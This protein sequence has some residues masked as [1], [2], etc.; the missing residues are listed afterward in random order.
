MQEAI[1]RLNAQGISS[2]EEKVFDSYLIEGIDLNFPNDVYYRSNS[3]FSPIDYIENMELIFYQD[4]VSRLEMQ[5][6]LNDPYSKLFKE[7]QVRYMFHTVS[8][9][10]KGYVVDYS[11]YINVAATLQNDINDMWAN[12]RYS[13]HMLQYYDLNVH[14]RSTFEV[15]T[16]PYLDLGLR[17]EV[18]SYPLKD[19]WSYNRIN[20]LAQ[21]APLP[22]M[23]LTDAQ[24]IR[25][26][27]Y[28][29]ILSCYG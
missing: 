1:D 18:K 5:K 14:P 7:R 28:K 4:T 13:S 9:N 22:N 24:L 20:L 16:R 17:Q 10:Y 12:L 21:T 15:G 26:M 8:E 6:A 27:S 23:G 11:Y 29:Q 3:S 19:I 2:S 25:T